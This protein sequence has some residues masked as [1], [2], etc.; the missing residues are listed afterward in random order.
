M[1]AFVF[2]LRLRPPPRSTRTDTLFPYT[3]LFRSPG[4]GP[5]RGSYLAAWRRLLRAGSHIFI[6]LPTLSSRQASAVSYHSDCHPGQATAGSASRD[7]WLGQAPGGAIGPGLR[8]R[9]A[10]LSEIGRAHV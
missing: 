9:D 4:C 8:S 5:W 7:P 10:R 3:T 2:F 1:F 6:A